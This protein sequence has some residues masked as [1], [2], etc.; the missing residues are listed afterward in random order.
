[1]IRKIA[2][3]II[4]VL[5]ILVLLVGAVIGFDVYKIKNRPPT[6]AELEYQKVYK[7]KAEKEFLSEEEFNELKRREQL[8]FQG[9]TSE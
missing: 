1:M 6:E 4:G 7:S 2:L 9:T 8:M 5:V 3:P